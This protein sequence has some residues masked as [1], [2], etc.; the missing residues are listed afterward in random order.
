MTKFK[1]AAL[2]PLPNTLYVFH[3]ALRLHFISTVQSLSAAVEQVT[4]MRSSPSSSAAMAASFALRRLHM[5]GRG[6]LCKCLQKVDRFPHRAIGTNVVAAGE[7][8]VKD[9]TG[10]YLKS[11]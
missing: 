5:R 10:E 3:S 4:R 11:S 8:A 2:F 9:D 7:A 6:G 1:V